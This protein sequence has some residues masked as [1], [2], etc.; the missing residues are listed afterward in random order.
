[1]QTTNG[2]GSTVAVNGY[3]LTGS[4]PSPAQ[5]PSPEQPPS[6][7]PSP[8]QP[9]SVAPVSSLSQAPSP[10]PSPAPSPEQS[11]AVSSKPLGRRLLESN[12]LRTV[13]DMKHIVF[14]GQHARSKVHGSLKSHHEDQQTV[15]QHSLQ[16][17]SSSG[18]HTHDDNKVLLTNPDSKDGLLRRQTAHVVKSG[19]DVISHVEAAVLPSMQKL[20]HSIISMAT[21]LAARQTGRRSL[22]SSDEDGVDVEVTVN[23][24]TGQNGSATQASIEGPDFAP[25]LQQSLSSEGMPNNNSIFAVCAMTSLM[26]C[27]HHTAWQYLFRV[28][29]VRWSSCLPA[30]VFVFINTFQKLHCHT[31]LL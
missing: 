1:M 26:L 17:S 22:A 18:Q 6:S 25:A 12:N 31:S 13:H 21:R 9:Q 24:P 20:V 19:L 15:L 4:A 7:A 14:M 27:L 11:P 2:S 29:L 30:V 16:M 3:T 10:V 28:Q 23:V 8:S 5:A